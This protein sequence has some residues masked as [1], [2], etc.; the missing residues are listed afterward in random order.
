MSL[1]D[2]LLK[3]NLVSKKDLKK[4]KHKE[5]VEKKKLGKD[6]VEKEKQKNL[7]AVEDKRREQKKKD[8]EKSKQAEVFKEQKAREKQ[9]QKLIR[10]GA[11]SVNLSGRRKY[12]FVTSE[13][14]IAFLNI[15]D[16]LADQLQYGKVVILEVF[17]ENSFIVVNKSVASQIEKVRADMICGPSI[18]N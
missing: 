5:R 2:Q 9:V 14:K 6:G 8:Q 18:V 12:Y 11:L 1:K 4:M 7:Q 13:K 15:D 16:K 10:E 3:A 17:E